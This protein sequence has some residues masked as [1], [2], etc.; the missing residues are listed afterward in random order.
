MAASPRERVSRLLSAGRRFWLES[1]LCTAFVRR[2]VKTLCAADF[3][4]ETVYTFHGPIVYYVVFLIQI[5]TRRVHIAGITANPDGAWMAQ[6]ATC[7]CTSPIRPSGPGTSSVI[8]QGQSLSAQ[9]NRLRA[10][11]LARDEVFEHGG[12]LG[13]MDGQTSLDR[14][15]AHCKWEMSA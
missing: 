1:S 4:T 12:R 7:A 9:I 3:C 11:M 13:K 10:F 15:Q 5:N 6:P 14:F 8:G 2:Q